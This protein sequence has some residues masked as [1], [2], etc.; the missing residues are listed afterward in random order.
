MADLRGKNVKF[1]LKVTIRNN[2]LRIHCVYFVSQE[3]IYKIYK[4]ETPTIQLCSKR[5]LRWVETS[6]ADRKSMTHL[7]NIAWHFNGSEFSV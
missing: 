7:Q 3:A 1:R 4:I 2:F 5:D 6:F